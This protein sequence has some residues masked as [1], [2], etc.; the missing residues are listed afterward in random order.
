M[1]PRL[2]AHVAAAL[3]TLGL[4]QA[5]L[6]HITPPVVLVSDRDAVVRLLP[7]ARKLA[8]REVRLTPE[9]QLAIKQATGWAPEE[10]FYR[11]YLGRDDQGRLLN[12][13]IFL[14]E[15]TIHG[16]VR[17]AVGLDPGGHISGAQVVELTEETYPWMKPLIDDDFTREYVGRDAQAS[18]ALTDRVK[19]SG[20]ASMPEFY[21]QIVASLLRRAALL[22]GVSGLGAA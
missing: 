2:V 16:P 7:G 22:Y 17:V 20:L 4:A 6:A 21:A 15:Y 3:A 19:R 5:A 11:F 1:T 8:V 18:F 13:S 10:P 9:Q 12:S 14:V